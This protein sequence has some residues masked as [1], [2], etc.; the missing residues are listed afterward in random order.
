[1]LDVD[2]R[3][4]LMSYE[5]FYIV[6]LNSERDIAA[7]DG[8]LDCLRDYSTC[9]LSQ[10]SFLIYHRG[11]ISSITETLSTVLDRGEPYTLFAVQ[12]P[13]HFKASDEVAEW[14]E[15]TRTIQDRL[16]QGRGDG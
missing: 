2:A 14:I 15:R 12:M 16:A 9:T 3:S 13:F 4:T 11:D 8:V 6:T 10:Q 5:H 7:H 1:L